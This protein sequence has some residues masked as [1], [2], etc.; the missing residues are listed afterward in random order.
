MILVSVMGL[1]FMDDIW[2]AMASRAAKL[3]LAT[4]NKGM[5]EVL[6]DNRV[7]GKARFQTGEQS[8]VWD[9]FRLNA[10][11]VGFG[12]VFA[13]LGFHVSLRLSHR[14]WREASDLSV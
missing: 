12:V 11:D 8:M 5:A 14:R 3:G 2:P 6:S 13:S 7:I 10:W 9:A 4:T 1:S